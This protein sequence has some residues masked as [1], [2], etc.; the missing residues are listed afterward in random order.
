MLQRR[1]LGDRD[2][3]TRVKSNDDQLI[4]E[5]RTPDMFN[6]PCMM[7]LIRS[8]LLYLETRKHPSIYCEEKQPPQTD[9][10]PLDDNNHTCK[11]LIFVIASLLTEC[12]RGS[13]MACMKKVT[14]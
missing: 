6:K 12:P 2:E 9:K 10:L 11:A 4:R 8:A 3:Q 14:V 7:G 1:S 5:T 13:V